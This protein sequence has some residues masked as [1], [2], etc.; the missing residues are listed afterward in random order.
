[1]TILEKL[2]LHLVLIDFCFIWGVE[3]EADSDL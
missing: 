3:E 2:I 1:M